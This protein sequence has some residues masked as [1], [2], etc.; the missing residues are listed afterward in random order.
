MTTSTPW[1]GRK[2]VAFVPVYRTVTLPDPPDVIPA[3]WPGAILRRVHYDPQQGGPDRSLRAWVRAASSGR[4]DIEGA[5]TA[6]VTLDRKHVE[7]TDLEGTLGDTLRGRGFDA[8]VLV[9]LGPGN[10]G[11]NAGFWSRVVMAEGNGVWLMEIIHGLTG[12]KD[13]YAFDTDTDPAANIIG[14]YDEMSASSLTHPT[15]FTKHELGW[16]DAP[17]I[18]RHSGASVPYSLQHVS[19]TQPPTS[20]RVAAVR[21]GDSLPYT[22]VEARWPTDQFDAGIPSPGVIAYRV[23]T[24][25]ATRQHRPGG[26]IPLFLLTTSA[27]TPGQSAPL[28]DGVILTVTDALVDGFAIRVDDPTRHHI[29][30]TVATGARRAEGPPSALVLPALGIENLTFR[31]TS[32]HVDEIWRDPLRSG[33]TDL[34]AQAGAP[35]ARGNPFTYFDPADNQVILVFRGSDARVR[36][37]YW[38]FGAVG[39][40]DLS[41]AVGAPA[42]ATDPAGWFSTHDG[43]H[44][45]VYGSSDGHLHE[46][47]WQGQGAVGHGDLTAAANAT[48]AAGDAHPSYDPVRSTNIVAFRGRDNRIRSLYWGP[49]G[50]VGQDDL[51]GTAG[52]PAAE[53]DPFIWFT[54]AEDAHR[55]IYRAHDDHIYELAW[56]GVAPVVGRSVTALA[57]SPRASGEATGG[58]NP[59]DNTQHVI[60]RS[61]DGHVHEL[62]WFVGESVVHHGDLTLS[63]GAP[64][65]ADRPVYYVT[66]TAPH[67][68]VGYRGNDSHIHELLW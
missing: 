46:L 55:V 52:T 19:L 62:W 21:I 48:P 33:T 61:A 11:T 23:Q 9:M 8:A 60:Y 14:G 25:D 35:G 65:A 4:A 17:V 34:T 37:L 59:A 12:F 39:H 20:D 58:Y 44:H 32:D 47:W 18:A 53:S 63:F 31:D 49:D 64:L 68:H 13:L 6:M 41:G 45:V 16:L 5:V 57:G 51:S 36:S 42:A 15:V 56:Y 43:F 29:D 24:D 27:L 50:A 2:R 30:R 10:A 3:D 40:D 28:D 38:M 26:K 7:A 66:P 1:L 22:I 54:A 67:H